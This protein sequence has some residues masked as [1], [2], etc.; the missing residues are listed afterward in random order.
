[1]LLKQDECKQALIFSAGSADYELGRRILS[2]WKELGLMRRGLII[3]ADGGLKWC[4]H[5]QVKPDILV[6]DFDSA[7]YDPGT[8]EIDRY[9]KDR[10]IR[11]RSFPPE[12]DWTD[13]Q[14]ALRQALN[15][16]CRRIYLLGGT[17]TRLDHVM[18]NIALMPLAL[19]E[20]ADL[21]LLDPN[22]RI[23][24]RSRPFSIL[25][26]Q[27][28][29]RYVSLFAFGGPVRGLTLRGMKYPLQDHTLVCEGSLGLS[30]EISEESAYIT[31]QSGRLIVAETGD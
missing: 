25:K 21:I 5:L 12:K 7:G 28:W 1:M 31:F 18:G 27:Q 26:K 9:R 22:N 30:N 23:Y 19:E 4:S 24:M 29:G 13:T 3:A 20:G 11:V 16:G 17:G 2:E 6:G 15:E 14:I 10:S 8:E